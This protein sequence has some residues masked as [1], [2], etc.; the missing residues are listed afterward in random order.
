MGARLFLQGHSMIGPRTNA[1]GDRLP[2][3]PAAGAAANQNDWT[4]E[5][6]LAVWTKGHRTY[7][8]SPAEWRYDDGGN[9]IYRSEYGNAH[10]V[11]GWM[12]DHIVPADRGGS[13]QLANLRPLRCGTTCARGA[14]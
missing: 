2:A 14:R 12:V 1:S 3:R 7:G 5:E 10:S 4:E 13:D 11:F 9:L 8:L 6:K